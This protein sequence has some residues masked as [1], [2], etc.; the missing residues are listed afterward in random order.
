MDVLASILFYLQE[1]DYVFFPIIVAIIAAFSFTR[2]KKAALLLW[3]LATIYTIDAVIGTVKYY[4]VSTFYLFNVF[5]NL[6]VF[7][8]LSLVDHS[9]KRL[10]LWVMCGCII[11]MNVYE[12]FN[13][14]QTFLYPYIDT[15]HSWC[16]EVL[17]AA[18]LIDFKRI[19]LWK[20]LRK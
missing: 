1:Y 9:N 8:L 10:V 2:D 15:I 13:M 6:V 4:D 12:H 5:I 16:L 14:Y 17:V 11:L 19:T 7:S 20:I 3:S 18:L